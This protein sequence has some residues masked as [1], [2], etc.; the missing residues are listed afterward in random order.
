M[1]LSRV[2]VNPTTGVGPDPA[3]LVPF[4]TIVLSPKSSKVPINNDA[5]LSNSF[6]HAQVVNEVQSKVFGDIEFRG[7]ARDTITTCP[8]STDPC[9]ESFV[10]ISQCSGTGSWEVCCKYVQS[11]SD[12][13]CWDKDVGQLLL[14]SMPAMLTPALLQLLGRV[15]AT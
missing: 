1:T 7:I 14:V 5:K 3:E 13:L 11:W 2:Y 8:A 9:L 6:V 4:S 12:E 10:G 15:C